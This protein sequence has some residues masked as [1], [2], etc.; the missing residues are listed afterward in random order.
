M[1]HDLQGFLMRFTEKL[2][3]HQHHKIHR[4]IVVVQQ[5]HLEEFGLLRF[6]PRPFEELAISLAFIVAHAYRHDLN[7]VSIES[8]F[9]RWHT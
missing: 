8:T 4:R 1:H 2:F 9:P 5:Q 7:R 6:V 3:Q